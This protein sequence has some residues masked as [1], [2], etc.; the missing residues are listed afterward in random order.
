[1]T[2]PPN[3][4][5]QFLAERL[6]DLEREPTFGYARVPATNSLCLCQ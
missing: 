3:L 5:L 2:Q 4:D 6:V 1:M